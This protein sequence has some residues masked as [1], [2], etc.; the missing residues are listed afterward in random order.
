MANELFSEA[1]EAFERALEI[2]PTRPHY[3]ELGIAAARLET[4]DEARAAFS[5]ALELNPQ[6]A[7]AHYNLGLI[8]FRVFEEEEGIQHLEK[9]LDLKLSATYAAQARELIENK[10][11]QRE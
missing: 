5:K 3:L 7:V 9:A 1:K 2:D 4:P 10:R 8:L 11:E 6:S